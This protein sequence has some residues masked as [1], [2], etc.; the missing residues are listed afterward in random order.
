[1]AEEQHLKPH[2]YT[3]REHP[4]K[5]CQSLYKE[6]KAH[7]DEIADKIKENRDFYNGIDEELEKR[8]SKKNVKR[9]CVF[10]HEQRPAI[11][12]GLSAIIDALEEGHNDTVKLIPKEGAEDQSDHIAEQEARLNEDLRD[13][14]FL[15]HKTQEMAR[16]SRIAPIVFIK[17]GYRIEEDIV[18][19]IAQGPID[20]FRKVVGWMRYSLGINPYPPQDRVVHRW[21]IKREGPYTE[22]KDW[23][24][25]HYD[26]ERHDY[27]DGR[28]MI[29]DN[30]YSKEE[31]ESLA[32]E[33]DWNE[34]EV[35]RMFADRKN[36]Q[37]GDNSGGDTV[38]DKERESLGYDAGASYDAGKYRVCEFWVP[39]YGKNGRKRIHKYF[40][41]EN[42]YVLSREKFGAPTFYTRFPFVGVANNKRFN[43][44]EGVPAVDL[45][46]GLQRLYNDLHNAIMDTV[47]Y[48]IFRIYLTRNNNFVEQPKM[49]PGAIWKLNDVNQFK[50]LMPDVSGVPAL[51]ALAGV[52]GQKIDQMHNAPDFGQAKN[53]QEQDEKV[54]QTKL[55]AMGSARRSRT[56]FKEIGEAV[57]AVAQW[58]VELYRMH[59]H[60]EWVFDANIDVP[61]LTGNYTPQEEQEKLYML[62]DQANKIQDIYGTPTGRLKKRNLLAEEYH[63]YRMSDIDNILPTEEEMMMEDQVL[64]LLVGMANEETENASTET[65]GATGDVGANE[66]VNQNAGV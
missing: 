2:A 36:K 49:E 52:I 26:P 10:V 66:G 51:T 24:E 63:K 7:S 47:T 40:L 34:D 12:T 18:H 59:D 16:E 55:R 58:W 48:N 27:Q 31:I 30:L 37:A 19:E 65:P 23:D 44:V 64:Q 43:Q 29:E 4:K 3:F 33:N 46:K 8:R 32:E 57:I 14:G 50:E 11:D 38:A 5:Y 39:V 22:L 54:F 9:S 62:V 20:R 28:A 13:D 6:F 53:I 15:T 42:E 21:D 25:V 56:D 17:V 61:A 45:T 35:K 1:M 60:V 41:G